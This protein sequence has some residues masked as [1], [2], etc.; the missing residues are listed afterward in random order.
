MWDSSYF[1]GWMRI[2]CL[3]TV[4]GKNFDFSSFVFQNKNELKIFSD[5]NG[6]NPFFCKP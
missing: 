3:N 2:M 6:T 4:R 5:V 1:H